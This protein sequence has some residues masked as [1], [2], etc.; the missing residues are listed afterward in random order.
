MKRSR[1][2]KGGARVGCGVQKPSL[3]G[4]D[5]LVLVEQATEAITTDDRSRAVAMRGRR[6]EGRVQP[7]ATMRSGAVVVVSVPP[8]HLL[9]DCHMNRAAKGEWR[10]RV[11]PTNFRVLRQRPE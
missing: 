8:E 4:G 9:R 2:V 1:P 5:P 7:A 11:W 10:L 6:A 3:S